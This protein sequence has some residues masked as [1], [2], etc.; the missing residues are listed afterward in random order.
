MEEP[1]AG[2]EPAVRW[3][4]DAEMAA[5]LNLSE[6]ITTLPAALDAHMQ[7][8]AG[9][10]FYEY[11]TMAMLSEQADRTLQLSVLAQA[12]SG[13]L[14]RLSHVLTRLERQGYVERHRSTENARARNAVLTDAGM[15][16]V[17]A[18][19]PCHVGRVRSLV[20]DALSAEDVVELEAVTER[21]LQRIRP[22]GVTPTYGRGRGIS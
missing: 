3:L 15:A 12:T 4:D 14:S 10:T 19:A 5:W 8:D 20:F 13:S 18:T 17:V 2:A 22:P 11:M 6:L 9:I 16:K 1:S 21:V 7:R